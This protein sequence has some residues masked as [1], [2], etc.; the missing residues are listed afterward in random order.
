MVV[1]VVLVVVFLE[2]FII[3]PRALVRGHV[4]DTPPHGLG[5]EVPVLEH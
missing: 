5:H 2:L 4:D 1:V 3:Q